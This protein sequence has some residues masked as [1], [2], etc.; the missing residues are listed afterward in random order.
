MNNLFNNNQIIAATRS[1]EEFSLALQSET[2]I[3]F[4]LCA[5]ILSLTKKIKAAHDGGKRLF[6]H[7]DL[8]EGV[9]RDKSGIMLL[10]KM[11]IDGI[12]STKVNL[13]KLAR[14]VGLHTVQR[15][16]I[17]DSKSVHTTIEAVKS[18]RP[19]M[20]EI[21]PATVGKVITRLAGELSTPIIAGGLIETHSEV[22]SAL[23]SG[24]TAVSTGAKTLWNGDVK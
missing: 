11:G 1:D 10:K 8:A 6:I 19:D 17:V 21:M 20:I 16:F 3:I 14:E 15:F 22:A 7:I 13:I 4:D 2:E 24:A 12:I 18:S 23:L 5:D 9:G